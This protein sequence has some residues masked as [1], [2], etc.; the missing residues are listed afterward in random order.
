MLVS[1]TPLG[2][3][4]QKC[5]LGGWG[6]EGWERWPHAPLTLQGVW[7]RNWTGGGPSPPVQ[8]TE[9]PTR[10]SRFRGAR[11]LVPRGCVPR[12]PTGRGLRSPRPV[13]LRCPV[14]G[15]LGC[16]T[17][18]CVTVASLEA[19]ATC[20]PLRW[21]GGSKGAGTLC[22]LVP[23]ALW[24]PRSPPLPNACTLTSTPRVRSPEGGSSV[25]NPLACLA[26]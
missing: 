14:S 10:G 13:W 8:R 18:G 23:G 26:L 4:M 2:R 5:V 19:G 1:D 24:P 12:V 11:P 9:S 20:H 17:G 21:E 15:V 6:G 22:R 16:N 3:E 7:G 25:Q